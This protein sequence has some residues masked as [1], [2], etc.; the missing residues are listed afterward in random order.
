MTRY[1]HWQNRSIYNAADSLSDEDRRSDWG[2]FFG[3]IHPTLNHLLW[4]RARGR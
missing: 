2:A 4:R 3:S 1:A